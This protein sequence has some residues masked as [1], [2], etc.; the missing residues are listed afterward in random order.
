MT[1]R[2]TIALYTFSMGRWHYLEKCIRSALRVRQE[3]LGPTRHIV[4]LQGVA[5]PD[6]LAEFGEQIEVIHW[7]QNCGI[8]EGIN[9]ISALLSEDIIIK[10]DDD[11]EIVSDRFLTHVAEIA[12]LCPQL[13]F[14]PFPV[15][16]IG[17][18][19][20]V[21]SQ[22][23]SVIY[24]ERLDT[25]YTLRA[26]PH[27]GGFC[28]ISPRLTTDWKLQPDLGIPGASGNEDVQFSALCGQSGIQ[29]AYLENAIIVEHQEST[30]GQHA[31]YGKSYFGDRF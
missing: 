4:C 28:R 3:Y 26:V 31:R 1:T 2:K 24:S 16:L 5:P 8:A 6:F 18:L 15:G 21:P 30:L 14:S 29:M 10:M 13:V 25:F 22:Q 23:R 19:G 12:T 7:P 11:C 17:N 20:G 9:R 27:V